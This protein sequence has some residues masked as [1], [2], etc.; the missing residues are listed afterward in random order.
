MVTNTKTNNWYKT[1]NK[2][3]PLKPIWNYTFGHLTSSKSI[4]KQ[5]QQYFGIFDELNSKINKQHDKIDLV[6]IIN[7]IIIKELG[8][9]ICTLY[10]KNDHFNNAEI[11]ILNDSNKIKTQ[12]ISYDKLDSDII[13]ALSNNKPFIITENI[14]KY[15]QSEVNKDIKELRC[16]PFVIDNKIHSLTCIGVKRFNHVPDKILNLILQQIHLIATNNT[17]HNRLSKRFVKNSFNSLNS[18]EEFQKLLTYGLNVSEKTNKALSLLLI[19]LKPITTFDVEDYLTIIDTLCF[20]IEKIGIGAKLNKSKLAVILPNKNHNHAHII[21]K[22][23][24]FD[25]SRLAKK[26]DTLI[27]VGISTYP[28]NSEDKESLLDNADNALTLAKKESKIFNRPTIINTQELHKR[29]HNTKAHKYI[30]HNNDNNKHLTDEYLN[31]LNIIKNARNH[32]NLTLEIISSLAGAIDAKDTYITN[33]SQSVAVYAEMFCEELGLDKQETEKIKLG[34]FLHDIG[35]IGIPEKVLDKPDK[36]DHNEWELIKTHPSIGARR[37]LQPI[38]A[39]NDVIPIVESHHERWDGSGYP[40]NLKGTEIPLGA[41]IV[42]IVDAFNTMTTDRPYRKS[43]GYD[44]AIEILKKE[45]NAQWD[46]S[47]VQSFLKI[48]QKAYNTVHN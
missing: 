19:D 34:A 1:F 13:Y 41:R 22:S 30:H 15:L 5:L 46:G 20:N 11:S 37:I 6:Q 35:K 26:S 10:I 43:L 18:H 40:H 45:S 21:A 48:A 27:N 47:L 16:Y 3:V 14:E 44:R 4:N 42:S 25:V 33:H 12:F 31:E 2:N 23:F 9:D 29:Q 28:E 39:L 32:H 7:K 8:Y 24:I 17:L 36:L 38:S